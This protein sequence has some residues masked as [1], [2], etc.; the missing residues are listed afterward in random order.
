MKSFFLILFLIP[1]AGL[2]Q[3]KPLTISG[4]VD[5]Y[6]GFDFSKPSLGDRAGFLYNHNRHNEV[7]LNLGFVKAAYQAQK[8]RGNLALATGTYMQ[9]N[10]AAEPTALRPIFE[11][12][13]G[14]KIGQNTWIDAGVM[15][16]HIGFES[17]ISKDC[18]T[19]S[20]SLMAEN[21]PYFETGIKLTNNPNDKL[22]WAV[23]FLNGWQRIRRVVDNSTPALGTQL[24]YKPNGKLTL[25]WS[26][27][28]GND[29]P[30]SLRQMRYFNN[31]YA[32]YQPTEKL[33]LTLGFDI[34]LEQTAK[35]SEDL[36]TWYTPIVMA[37]FKTSEKTYIALRTEYYKDPNGVIISMGTHDFGVFGSSLNF[38]YQIVENFL[39]RTEAKWY[40]SNAPVFP[41]GNGTS[42]QNFALLTSLAVSF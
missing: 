41:Q 31:F 6:Y 13:V 14:V 26:T 35:G 15:P 11:A 7:N 25:N 2:P 12:N 9:Y 20:R 34:G 29:K 18:W 19:L 17:A 3:D 21:S 4:F 16:S 5:I 27:F 36:N 1:L 22:T 33:G 38:D 39:W 8:I 32:I 23:L 30:D 28:V 37:R 40:S 42:Q 10:Y 24:T